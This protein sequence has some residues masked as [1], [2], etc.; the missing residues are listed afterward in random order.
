MKN[1]KLHGWKFFTVLILGAALTRL[2][3]HYPNFTAVGSIALFGGAVFSKKWQAFLV[4]F[5]AMLLTDMLL[6][7][8]PGMYAVYIS[9]ALI[10][11]IGMSLKNRMTFGNTV[12]AVFMS[13]V[14]FFLITNFAM[15]ATGT[16][17]PKT[18]LGLAEC[19]TAALP[20]FHFSLLGDLFF[21]AV[22]FGAY[23]FAKH[24]APALVN[25]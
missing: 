3:P 9:F 12:L 2:I 24:K 1:L 21:S 4:P 8:H 20:F 15:W 13:S 19:F 25:A 16:L 7:F 18:M 22:L 6:G 17:Y 23:S 5:S 14:S 11:A 10:V